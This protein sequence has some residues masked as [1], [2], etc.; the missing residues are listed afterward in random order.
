[1]NTKSR[2]MVRRIILIAS[3]LALLMSF[4]IGLIG[5]NHIKKAY[6]TSFQEG[7]HAAAIL[8]EDE[9]S[10]QISGDWTLGEDGQL[11]KG[12]TPVHDLYQGQL[13]ELNR[14]TGMHYTVFFGDTRYITSLK[15]AETGV[16]ME[17]TKA[18]D[19]VV[20]E[21]LRKGDEY[22]AANFEIANQNWYAYYLPLKNADGSV[23][24]MIF[25]GRDTTIVDGNMR[26]AGLAIIATFLIFFVFN[27]IVARILITKTSNSIKDITDGLKKLEDGELSFYIEDRTFNRKDELGVIAASS[28]QVRDKLQD[29]ISA[30]KKLSEDVTKSGETLASSAESASRVAEQV[31]CAVEDISR[32]AASQAE[33]ME[34][35]VNN[36]NEMGDSID[37]ITDRIES[38]SAAADEMLTGANR[39]VDTLSDLMNKNEDVM[40]SMKD[41]NDQ[42]RL[43]NDSVMDIAE[44]SNVITQIAEQTHLLSLNATIEAAR[45]GDYGKGFSVV[46][47]EIGILSSES[48]KA[49]VSISQIVETLVAESKKS[50]ETM[51]RLGESMQ[52]QNAQLTSTKDDMDVVVSNVNNVD[53]STRMISEKIH[54]LNQLKASFTDIISELSAI[55][56]QN[57][58]STEETNASM[59]ELNST[60]ALISNAANDLRDMAETLNEKMDFFSL[61]KMSA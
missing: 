33:S 41:I 19:V 2:N 57:A 22:L 52:E 40:T 50:V 26:A 16:R 44:A 54:L 8:L 49:A 38:L 37:E 17:G 48:K 36:T 6:F 12:E 13:D 45:A 15:D 25:A 30:T 39:T 29:V 27:L 23:I 61:D 7:L 60:F 28:A 1:M 9:L 31:T 55:S 11:L 10:N 53:N 34:S 21:V 3:I 18:S 32:G 42:I 43:T 46:A 4:F 5:F 56:Q 14:K 47:S 51:Q 59:E 35:S 20:D 24:G 58:A